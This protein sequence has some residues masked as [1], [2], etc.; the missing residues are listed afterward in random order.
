MTT[1]N[2]FTFQQAFPA[3]P[4]YTYNA[5][6]TKQPPPAGNA[7]KQ[8]SIKPQHPPQ[9]DLFQAQNP[10]P[11]DKQPNSPDGEKKA[12]VH[13]IGF[14]FPAMTLVGTPLML[15]T[16]LLGV[17][18]KQDKL[19]FKPTR[20]MKSLQPKI[21]PKGVNPARMIT[22]YNVGKYL[23]ALGIVP[24]TIIGMMYGIKSEQPSMLFAHLLQLPIT[25]LIM[26]EHPIATSLAYMMGGTFTLGFINDIENEQLED[27]LKG[28]QI[29][30]PR[31]Y[32]MT[33][34]KNVFDPNSSMSLA[35][36]M[37]GFVKEVG[38]MTAFV[39]EDHWKTGKRAV[40][41]VTNLITGKKSGL[42]DIETTGSISKSSL[43]FLL[44]YMATIP[45]IMSGLMLKGK[46]VVAERIAK[47]SIGL[48]I[49]SGVFLN[50][51]MVLVALAGKNWAEKIPLVGTGMEL[52]GTLAGYSTNNRI[53]PF[54]V[55]F[56]QLGAGLN[57]IFF[58]NR[59]QGNDE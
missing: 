32:D 45:A 57:N 35:E 50:F 7:F 26:R 54:A 44:C 23:L 14:L 8:Q 40:Q 21:A 53:Q 13:P 41:E 39:L 27:G 10:A 49:L 16:S 36:R 51:G 56:Q 1:P 5:Y 31:R 2:P 55:A 42:T 38:K 20:L 9:K 25:P 3:Y 47:L 15:V 11:A 6:N 4:A 46:G 48:T 17:Q 29:T 59:A 28:V 12:K 34:I 33:T 43:G 19:V 52:S 18:K 24:K 22:A 30:K 37:S 58:A